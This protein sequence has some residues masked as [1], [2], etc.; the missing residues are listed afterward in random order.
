VVFGPEWWL[1]VLNRISEHPARLHTAVADAL[2]PGHRARL[3]AEPL[4]DAASSS[5]GTSH[6]HAT[7][8][9]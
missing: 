4:P 2:E 6:R 9:A 8:S 1:Y 5:S 7:E 3:Q